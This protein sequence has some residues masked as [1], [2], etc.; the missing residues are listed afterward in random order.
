LGAQAQEV[1]R[2]APDQFAPVYSDP[3]APAHRLPPPPPP[4]PKPAPSVAAK[5][6]P[7]PPPVIPSRAKPF[8]ACEPATPSFVACLGSAAELADRAVEDGEHATLASLAHRPDMNPVIADGAARGLRAAGDAWRALRDRECADLPL[9][10]NGL[11]GSL[12][13]RRLVCR[14]R[15]DIE[16]VETLKS[17][18]GVP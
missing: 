3:N 11:D 13:Q 6:P 10:E 8:G 4:R 2:I 5:P 16:R 1:R 14:I 7:P 17:R 12:Y 15:R 9:I 18:Y